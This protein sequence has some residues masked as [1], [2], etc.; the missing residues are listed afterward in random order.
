MI[1]HYTSGAN[2]T[3]DSDY[4]S[5]WNFSQLNSLSKQMLQTMNYEALLVPPAPPQICAEDTG[6]TYCAIKTVPSKDSSFIDTTIP[7]QNQR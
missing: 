3:P 7:L 4:E 1:V 2:P 5:V 6:G